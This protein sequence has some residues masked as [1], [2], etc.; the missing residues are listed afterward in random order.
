MPRHVPTNAPSRLALPVPVPAPDPVEEE[1]LL[2]DVPDPVEE[3]SL[4]GDVP[5]PIEEE[6]FLV[7]ASEPLEVAASHDASMAMLPRVARSCMAFRM[8][9]NLS[10]MADEENG[11]VAGNNTSR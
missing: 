8:E 4:L 9:W 5:D 6:S 11:N 1:S 2:G 7:D 3:E 10:R